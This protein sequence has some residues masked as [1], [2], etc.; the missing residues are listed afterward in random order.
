MIDLPDYGYISRSIQQMDPGGPVPGTM[1]GPS[2]YVSRPGLRLS[3]AFQ[4]RELRSA[5]EAAAFENM[6]RRGS[7][8]DVSYPFP[9][10]FAP[11]PSSPVGSAPLVNGSNPAG[12]VLNIKG[13]LPYYQFREG[14]PVAVISG[15]L[16]YV[17]FATAVTVAS[18]TGTVALPV[19][20]WTR[21]TF[22]N[23]DV[24]EIAR[25]RIR[26]ILAWDGSDQPAY[27]RRAFRFTIAERR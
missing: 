12:G 21:T 20:P 4:L 13:L 26:G 3:V 14:Q 2:D 7:Q 22:A 24:V 8:E 10:D 17:H 16:G 15:G 23:G 27:G 11:G 18:N 9:L 1:G 6:L 5:E 19:F 25:P